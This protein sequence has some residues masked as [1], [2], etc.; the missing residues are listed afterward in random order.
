MSWQKIVIIWSGIVKS[1][2]FSI[3]FCLFAYYKFTKTIFDLVTIAEMLWRSDDILYT[4]TIDKMLKWMKCIQDDSMF[5]DELLC[6]R[7]NLP[8]TSTTSHFV[9]MTMISWMEKIMWTLDCS[10]LICGT[11]IMDIDTLCGDMVFARSQYL[12]IDNTTR[13][14]SSADKYCLA[15]WILSNTYSSVS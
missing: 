3:R 14:N 11:Y 8:F 7:D 12:G 2:L 4:N 15:I 9:I 1:D 10:E 13:Q 5:E 6:I